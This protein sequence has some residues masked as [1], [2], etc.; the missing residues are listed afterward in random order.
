MWERC[1]K[2]IDGIASV[3]V[4]GFVQEYK[5]TSST[6]SIDIDGVGTTW[7]LDE[8]MF[9]GGMTDAPPQTSG[10]SV[11]IYNFAQGEN[12]ITFD[13]SNILRTSYAKLRIIFMNKNQS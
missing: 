12:C 1:G 2:I 5:V 13:T 6:N 4:S 10:T 7:I 8:N 11:R 9:I 3:G